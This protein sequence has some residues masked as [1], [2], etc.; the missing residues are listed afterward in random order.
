M[1]VLAPALLYW[2]GNAPLADFTAAATDPA[3]SASYYG[4]LLGELRTL[5]VGYGR[6][7]RA[8]RSC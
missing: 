7:R 1:L 3:V 4:P 6:A 8:S 2:Q 5:G